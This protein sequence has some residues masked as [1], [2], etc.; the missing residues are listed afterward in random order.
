[1]TAGKTHSLTINE[2]KA[3]QKDY[4]VINCTYKKCKGAVI[5]KQFAGDSFDIWLH[6]LTRKVLRCNFVT[7]V[8]IACCND[9][10]GR[11]GNGLVLHVLYFNIM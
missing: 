7:F 10:G 6:A 2:S 4:I 3:Q 5:Y 1:M 9:F 8:L 11:N